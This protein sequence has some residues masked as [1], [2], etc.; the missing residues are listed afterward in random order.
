MY[1]IVVSCRDLVL[2]GTRIL[3]WGGQ[4][5]GVKPPW[6]ATS[7]RGGPIPRPQGWG[8]GEGM[9]PS[10]KQE[11]FCILASKCVFSDHFLLL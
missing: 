2:G 8:Q 10:P 9:C 3:F 6:S 1:D 4:K 11:L 5:N 7:A